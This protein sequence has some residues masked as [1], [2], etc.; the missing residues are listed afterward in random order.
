VPLVR[1]FVVVTSV[2]LAMLAV[3]NWYLPSPPPLPNQAAEIDKTTLRIRS[4]RKWPQKIEFDTAMDPFIAASAPRTVASAAPAVAAAPREKP[5]LDALAQAKLPEA[6][7][8]KPKSKTRSVRRAPRS[9][10]RVV[11][12]AN[13]PTPGW[14]FGWGEP[15]PGPQKQPVDSRQSS[16][17]NWFGERNRQNVAS[18]GWGSPNDW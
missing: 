13:P 3:A 16:R 7:I 11:V 4:E 1:Y 12:A 6:E 2:L 14:S 10:P 15:T 8:A 5:A 9:T 17:N 18:R